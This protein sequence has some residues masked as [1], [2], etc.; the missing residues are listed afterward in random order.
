MASL[1]GSK[2]QYFIALGKKEYCVTAFDGVDGIVCF[3]IEMLSA[4][5]NTG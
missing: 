2:F 5:H 4:T 3:A 1:S